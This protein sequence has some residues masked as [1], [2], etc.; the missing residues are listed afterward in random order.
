MNRETESEQHLRAVVFDVDG[1]LIDSTD[2]IVECFLRTFRDLAVLAPTR[3]TIIHGISR[4]VE[5]QFR[6]LTDH[7]PDECA[8]I[9]R[10]HYAE[11]GCDMTVLL[12]RV[13]V[14]LARLAAAGLRLGIATSRSRESTEMLLE[15]FGVFH[16]FDCC[17]GPGQV[18]HPKPHPEPVLKALKLLDTATVHACFVGDTKY[19]INAAHAAG[20]RSIAVTTGYA[21]RSELL[22]LCPDAVFDGIEAAIDYILSLSRP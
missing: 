10:T 16:Y 20:V 2:A 11:I 7:D 22:K 18:T 8:A 1:T 6:D 4:P 15:H 14:G 13:G 5:D 19:D 21:S 17:I 9:Y 3:D 12:P